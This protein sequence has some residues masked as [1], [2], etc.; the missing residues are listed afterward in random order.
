[1]APWYDTEDDFDYDLLDELSGI[2]FPNYTKSE[3][4]NFAVD[5]I[6]QKGWIWTTKRCYDSYSVFI[7]HEGEESFAEDQVLNKAMFLCLCDALAYRNN[8]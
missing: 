4:F 2:S 6:S 8:Q 5:Y 3:A 7:N 1:M